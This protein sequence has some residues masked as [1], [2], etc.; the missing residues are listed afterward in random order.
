MSGFGLDGEGAHA[1]RGGLTFYFKGR[2]LVSQQASE[3]PQV[4]AFACS[5]H[6]V[7]G[8]NDLSRLANTYEQVCSR[9][10]LCESERASASFGTGRGAARQVPGRSA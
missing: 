3:G 10:L 4:N 9:R 7:L 6:S 2:S 5:Q 8:C 1:C